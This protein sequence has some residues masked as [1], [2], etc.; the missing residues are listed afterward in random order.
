MS[1]RP[2][3]L[4]LL[5]RIWTV[6]DLIWSLWLLVL[7]PAAGELFL[8][9]GRATFFL[10]VVAVAF[11]LAM[12]TGDGVQRE[13]RPYSMLLGVGSCII[14]VDAGFRQLEAPQAMH[15]G[16]A[17][18]AMVLVPL[19]WWQHRR[20]RPWLR[21]S[22]LVRRALVWPYLMAAAEQFT[23]FAEALVGPSDLRPLPRE[24]I[25]ELIFFHAFVY[26]A[27]LPLV[28]FAFVAAP[29]RIVHRDDDAG[30]GAWALRYGFGLATALV[31]TWVIAPLID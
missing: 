7:S 30:L 20:G 13:A 3:W 29:R 16:V 8:E 1:T 12:L 28:Y 6:E 19:L 18:A 4:A 23:G 9:G 11:A 15:M 21:I 10:V 26:A 31:S 25:G 27:I 17:I 24:T 5:R 22:P 14:L 2:H